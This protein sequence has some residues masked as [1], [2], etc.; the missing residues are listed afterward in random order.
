MYFAKVNT[1][2]YLLRLEKGEQ[3]N[4]SSKKFCQEKSIQNASITALGS[5]ENPTLAHYRVDTK[6]YR[7]ERLTGIFE[8]A[9]LTG[10]IGMFKG[11]PFVHTHVTVTDEKMRAFG[12]HLVE[13]TVSATVE[14]FIAD[15]GTDFG[16]SH[17]EEIGL[18]LWDLPESL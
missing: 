8:L 2:T 3:L 11:Q 6:K 18:R 16:K 17:S 7:E 10:T 13:A 5:I 14:V 9:N 15:L 12:G 4:A 1:N